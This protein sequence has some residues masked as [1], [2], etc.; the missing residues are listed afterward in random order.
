VYVDTQLI[1]SVEEQICLA[2]E[3]KWA[4]HDE[5]MVKLTD[6]SKIALAALQQRLEAEFKAES[7]RLH[8]ERADLI[9]QADH[10]ERMFEREKRVM[11]QE[12]ALLAGGLIEIMGCVQVVHVPVSIAEQFTARYQR[13]ARQVEI[14]R[15]PLDLLNA[16][17]EYLR[18]NRCVSGIL[19][20]AALWGQARVS[21]AFTDLGIKAA[22]P[23]V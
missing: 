1:N 13:G 11:Q 5:R 17:I 6:D 2:L 23:V 15:I 4:A 20:Y 8:R 21:Q 12:Q 18:D 7:V 14:P 16:I 22:C 9:Q 19:K 3:S 10:E